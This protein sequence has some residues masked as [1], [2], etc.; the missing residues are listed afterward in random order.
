MGGR[1]RVVVLDC[2][3]DD[4]NRPE[5]RQL[6]D[7][8]VDVRIRGYQAAYGYGVLPLDGTD[9]IGTHVLFCEERAQSLRVVSTMKSVSYERCR[10]FNAS[11][12]AIGLALASK[13]EHQVRY[14][15][16]EIRDA[17]SS[18]TDISYIAGWTIDPV[19]KHENRAEVPMLRDLY[20]MANVFWHM[21]SGVR[22]IL[23]GG[24]VRFKTDRFFERLGF[25]Y[26]RDEEGSPLP[27]FGASFAFGEP[28]ILLGLRSH[29]R[30]AEETAG[31]LRPLWEERLVLAQHE[32]R[33]ALR[34]AA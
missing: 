24:N 34:R 28:V 19:W 18:G 22:R 8:M 21:E 12:P 4:F 5:T 30:F 14:V 6:F 3:Y 27:S 20:A 9:F 11:F 29:S 26:G 25:E 31:R 16:R 33:R 32:P 17:E 7:Q 1:W 2:P 13:Q 15:E 10:R 23:I